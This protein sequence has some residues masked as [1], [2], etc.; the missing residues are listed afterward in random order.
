MRDLHDRHCWPWWELHGRAAS[1][2]SEDRNDQ[3]HHEVAHVTPLCVLSKSVF[4]CPFS[5]TG[6]PGT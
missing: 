3:N 1:G 4:L 6:N 2:G 5:A